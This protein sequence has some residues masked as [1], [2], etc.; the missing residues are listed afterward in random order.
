MNT[1]KIALLILALGCIITACKKYP[2][3]YKIKDMYSLMLKNPDKAVD[4]ARTSAEFWTKTYD[5]KNGGFFTMVARNGDVL[6][7]NYK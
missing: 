7:N 2:A 4:F 5:E 1:R 6:G 3:E